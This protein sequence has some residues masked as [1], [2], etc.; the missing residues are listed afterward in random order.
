MMF[1]QSMPDITTDFRYLSNNILIPKPDRVSN[2]A[3]EYGKRLRLARKES[4][5]TQEAAALKTGIRQSTISTAEREGAGSAETPVYAEAYG[6][7]ALWLA[8]GKGEKKP[9][10][11]HLTLSTTAAAP[12]Q[13]TA[14]VALTAECQVMCR[15]F[16]TLPEDQRDGVM[17]DIL[18]L[19]QHAREPTE[20]KHLPKPPGY[21]RAAA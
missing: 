3:T 1:F 14:P 12:A 2:M 10:M 13:E 16:L 7:N 8:N 20:K 19:I 9:P 17:T 11:S 18:N 6:V 15:M 5:F 4:G 21:K